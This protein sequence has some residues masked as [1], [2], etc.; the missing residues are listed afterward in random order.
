LPPKQFFF[1][2]GVVFS[3]AITSVFTSKTPIS[4]AA[5]STVPEQ[6][7]AEPVVDYFSELY[8]SGSII[9]G[10]YKKAFVVRLTESGQFEAVNVESDGY[11]LLTLTNKAAVFS[12][13]GKIRALRSADYSFHPLRYSSDSDEL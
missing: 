11:K 9:A 2:V 10:S 3:G 6:S 1:I 4:D 8:L 13:G 7:S 12:K 5:A